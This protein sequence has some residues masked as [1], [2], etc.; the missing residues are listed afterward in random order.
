MKGLKTLN[1]VIHGNCLYKQYKVHVLVRY[2][3]VLP[4]PRIIRL[5]FKRDIKS[6]LM[7]EKVM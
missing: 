2:F 1:F 5:K 3:H 4:V 6:K 7:S